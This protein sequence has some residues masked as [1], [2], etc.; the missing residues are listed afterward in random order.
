[1]DESHKTDKKSKFFN[2]K[3]STNSQVFINHHQTINYKI[4]QWLMV[5]YGSFSKAQKKLAQ[6]PAL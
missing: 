5:A 3:L 6:K 4:N 2:E 1:M